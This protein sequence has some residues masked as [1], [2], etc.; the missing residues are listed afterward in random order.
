MTVLCLFAHHRSASTW[1]RGILYQ[2]SACTGWR[3]DTIHDPARLSTDLIT[4]CNRRNLELLVFTNA[5]GEFMEQL[6]DFQGVHLVRDPR[7]ILVS[8]YFSH[9][10]SHPTHEWPELESHRRELQ[11]MDE[12]QGL[13]RELDC[14][15]QQF[16][17]MDEWPYGDPRVME[18]KLEQLLQHQVECFQQL[19]NFWGYSTRDRFPGAEKLACC[20][21]KAC[22]RLERWFPGSHLPR[23]RSGSVAAGSIQRIIQRNDFGSKTGG[24]RPGQV[25][26]H[27]HY[28]VG[29]PGDWRRHFTPEVSLRFKQ[30]YGGLLVR[31]GYEQSMD[32]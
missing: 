7:D 31:L 32:W 21:N 15:A 14:R 1:S 20:Y 5:R 13:L 12:E 17:E 22:S 24:R 6:P 29:I 3:C 28:R 25:D 27:H 19:L 23:W 8:S 30:R 9:R 26:T 10:F 18:W 11:E 4:H 2:L 16:K